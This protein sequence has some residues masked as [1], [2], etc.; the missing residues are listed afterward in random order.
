MVAPT[1]LLLGRELVYRNGDLYVRRNLSSEGGLQFGT[2][3]Y[4]Q[5]Q[6]GDANELHSVA[7]DISIDAISEDLRHAW[8]YLCDLAHDGVVGA[9]DA[10]SIYWNARK[11]AIF[12]LTRFKNQF[13]IFLFQSEK[14][15][16]ALPPN[17]NP[18]ITSDSR[19]TLNSVEKEL[20]EIYEGLSVTMVFDPEGAAGCFVDR[21]GNLIDVVNKEYWKWFFSRTDL[22]SD[23]K[24]AHVDEVYAALEKFPQDLLF[25]KNRAEIYNKIYKAMIADGLPVDFQLIGEIT[26]RFLKAWQRDFLLEDDFDSS[27]NSNQI[28]LYNQ[29]LRGFLVAARHAAFEDEKEAAIFIGLLTV[30]GFSETAAQVLGSVGIISGACMLGEMAAAPIEILTSEDLGQNERIAFFAGVNAAQGAEFIVAARMFGGAA[31]LGA[32]LRLVMARKFALV[33]GAPSV[34]NGEVENLEALANHGVPIEPLPV[35]NWKWMLFFRMRSYFL[36]HPL[37]GLLMRETAEYLRRGEP[38][39]A[40]S[41]LYKLGNE[42][43]N[44][45]EWDAAEA[46]WALGA[47]VSVGRGGNRSFAEDPEIIAVLMNLGVLI[48]SEISS[49]PVVAR[50]IGA[51]RFGEVRKFYGKPRALKVW[52][53]EAN[54]NIFSP[55]FIVVDAP[56]LR[57]IEQRIRYVRE[58]AEAL[59]RL[60]TNGVP[61]VNVYLVGEDFIVRDF[62]YGPTLARI[63]DPIYGLSAAEIS[64]ARIKFAQLDKRLLGE[65]LLVDR[66]NRHQNILYDIATREWTVIDP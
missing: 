25:G 18:A 41:L 19:E 15:S 13:R 34:S 37:D 49:D 61:A 53:E 39:K 48:T 28:G 23:A 59:E 24:L 11:N 17:L 5:R 55:E 31:R 64:Q 35:D 33:G 54:D 36:G 44:N 10:H 22:T 1:G 62:V 38:E 47:A 26:Y 30:S 4:F 32:S 66:G 46:T 6:I 7:R 3:D 16:A 51:G 2:T 60:R 27:D 29:M 45:R 52:P 12:T 21:D 43:W 9:S 8:K 63:G 20:V 57:T 58:Q 56:K 40:T 65:D 42:L 14:L 50:Y